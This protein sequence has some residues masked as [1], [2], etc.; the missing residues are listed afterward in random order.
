MSIGD[1]LTAMLGQAPLVAAAVAALYVLFSREIG[2]VEMRIGRLEGQ[3]GELGGRLDRLEER[4]GR[5][6]DRVGNL[7]NQVGKLESRMGALEDRMGRLEGQV[8]NIGKQVDSLREQMGKLESRMGA[9]EDRMGRLEDRVG[10]L[11]G[12][13]GDLG[14]RMDKIEEQLAG[15]GRSFQIYNST[16][17]KVLSTKG[18]LTGVE[19]EALAGY[20]SLV[21]PAR[22][23]YYTEE[24][25]QRLIE[26]I[27]AVREG[28]YT[29]ADVRELGRIAELMEKEWEETGRRD[30]L[31]YYLKLQMLV[32]ILEGILVSRGEWPREELWA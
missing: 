29:A 19:A 1:V 18:V 26:L 17:P 3:I 5:L 13:I 8:G 30:L 15:L 9:L 27:K 31:D 2:R 20:L 11:E 24:V 28:R 16:L 12:Q 22:S 32:A 21:P 4:V 14:G 7:E 10:K 23:K 25:R 6:E